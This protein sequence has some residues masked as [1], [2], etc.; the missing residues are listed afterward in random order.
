MKKAFAIILLLFLSLSLLISCSEKYP[1][2]ASTDSES[3]VLMQISLGEKTY[4]VKYELYRALFLSLKPEIDGGDPS[5][6]TCDGK[7][8]YIN[9]INDKINERIADIYSVFSIAENIGID[10]YSDEYN[11]MVDACIY[12]GVEGGTVGEFTYTGF[13]GDYQK[14][15]ESLKEMN[16]NYSVQD[17]MLRYALAMD[18]IYYYYEGNIENDATLGHLD[19]TKDDVKAFYESEE[20]VRVMQLFISTVS[21]SFTEKTVKSV[22]DKIAAATSEDE[23]FYIMMNNSTTGAV[24]DELRQGEL[25]GRHNLDS[26]YYS[27]LVD[28]AFALS[29]FE[30]SEP[31]EVSTSINRGYFILYR[32]RKTDEHFEDYYADI[33]NI[34]VANRIGE[35]LDTEKEL[36]LQSTVT[37]DAFDALIYSD[38]SMD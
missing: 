4:D 2:V 8:E 15:L 21:T 37:T 34:Y 14:Y 35:I 27:K 16:L 20:C 3:L 23:V 26:Y 18:D 13:G 38:I 22:R 32:I 25:I 19:Y 6:W 30:T 29:Y 10:I 24:G 9:K 28:A 7:D 11:K 33:E 36:V 1:P 12:A 5:V 31:I 17:L